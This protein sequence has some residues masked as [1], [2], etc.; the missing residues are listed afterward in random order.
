[1][2]LIFIDGSTCTVCFNEITGG[3][4]ERCSYSSKPKDVS[5][6]YTHES[7]YNSK[8]A[9]EKPKNAESKLKRMK[10]PVKK[11]PSSIQDKLEREPVKEIMR[12][13]KFPATNKK[14]FRKL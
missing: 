13:N 11:Y 12:F 8:D 7:N 10:K 3:K 6:A 2:V 9:K 5:Y 4:S 1:M 14:S